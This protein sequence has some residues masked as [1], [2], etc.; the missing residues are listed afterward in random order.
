MAR[1]YYVERQHIRIEYGHVY[2]TSSASYLA[3]RCLNHLTEQ[4]VSTYPTGALCVERDFYVDD[5]LTDADTILDTKLIPDQTIDLLR[6]GSFEL[7]KWASN[8]PQLLEEIEDRNRGLISISEAIDCHVLEVQWKQRKDTFHFTYESDI[9]VDIV[10]SKRT[11]LSE[12]D[13]LFS[14][15]GLLD[16]TIVVAKIIF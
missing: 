12:I 1:R 15:L 3:T 13:K 11:I 9:S 8:C 14:P 10:L 16:P 5:L 2:G 4:H 6:L 7:G